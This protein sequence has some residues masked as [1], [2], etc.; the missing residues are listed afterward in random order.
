MFFDTI[1]ETRYQLQ[2]Q[3]V[4]SFTVIRCI[5]SK[6]DMETWI[7]IGLNS[8]IPDGTTPE[9]H[10]FR[11]RPRNRLREAVP[12]L[13]WPAAGQAIITQVFMCFFVEQNYYFYK[14]T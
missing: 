12:T 14:H 11:Y 4:P 8:Q 7:W 1:Q 6:F 3:N 13:G 10:N 5:I 2:V 9:E